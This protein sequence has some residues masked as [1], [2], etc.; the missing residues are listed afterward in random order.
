MSEI[1]TEILPAEKYKNDA[2]E[3]FKRKN[4]LYIEQ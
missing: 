4:N 3:Y 2:N 1:N